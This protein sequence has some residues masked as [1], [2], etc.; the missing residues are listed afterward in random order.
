MLADVLLVVH[1]AIA[2]FI[3]GG[4]I[5]V[6]I[7]APLGWRWIRNPWFRYLHVAAIA[8]VAVEALLGV[9]CPLTVWE[10]LL[11]GGLRPESFVAR[12]A[13]RLLYYRAPEWVFSAA[14]LAWALATLLTLRL[15][16]PRRRAA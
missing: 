13:Y 5:L 6:W 8:F 2:A 3:V 4:L 9:A 16:P 10:D 7:G 15:V 11:R 14:Y 12:W 1:F